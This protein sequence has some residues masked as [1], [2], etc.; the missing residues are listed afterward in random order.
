[1]PNVDERESPDSLQDLAGSRSRSPTEDEFHSNM[2]DDS[3]M[4]GRVRFNPE[5]EV[6]F[7][8]DGDAHAQQRGALEMGVTSRLPTIADD[9][10]YMYGDL[11]S[12][13]PTIMDDTGYMCR[14]GIDNKGRD[15]LSL[16]LR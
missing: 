12:R 11:T 10:G 1:M 3:K 8:Q 9:S 14:G 2:T 7:T 5:P 13:M 16:D 15:S 6:R 4:R